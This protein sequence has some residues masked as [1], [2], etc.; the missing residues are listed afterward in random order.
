[1]NNIAPHFIQWPSAN[2]LFRT[3]EGFNEN[4]GLPRCI[5]ATDGTHIPIKAPH[6]HDGYYINRKG[7]HSMQLQVVCH[8]DM[9]F[10]NVCYGWPGA[11]HVAHV[12]RNGPLFYDAE[13]RIN[14]IFPGH[15]LIL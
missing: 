5:G 9:I 14:D 7:F 15:Q 1:M 10:T 2:R 11:V 13:T 3:I 8:T 4:N 12:L 6:N